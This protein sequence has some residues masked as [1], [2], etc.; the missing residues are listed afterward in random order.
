MS[1][2]VVRATP[3]SSYFEV[4]LLHSLTSFELHH[5]FI[6]IFYINF[7]IKMRERRKKVDAVTKAAE[8]FTS[9]QK[10]VKPPKSV[11]KLL[12]LWSQN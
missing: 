10:E 3:I 9:S 4:K 6:Y 8:A 11:S 12:V 7:Q 5:Q 1:S 2:S